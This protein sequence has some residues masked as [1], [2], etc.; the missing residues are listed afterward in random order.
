[1]SRSCLGTKEAV[2]APFRRTAMPSGGKI[3]ADKTKVIELLDCG[4]AFPV[5]LVRLRVV[6]AIQTSV[7]LEGGSSRGAVMQSCG[8]RE[9]PI[10][11]RRAARPAGFCHPRQLPAAL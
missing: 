9:G 7:T 8:G 1:V 4:A 6:L 11:T 10:R 5:S 3:C 2:D